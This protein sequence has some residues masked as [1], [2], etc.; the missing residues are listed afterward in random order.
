MAT[1]TIDSNVAESAIAA[2]IERN[3]PPGCEVRRAPLPAADIVIQSEDRIIMLERKTVNDFASSMT[4][5][6]LAE[7]VERMVNA[8]EDSDTPITP[9]ILI[10]GRPPDYDSVIDA[11]IK[12]KHFYG[13]MNRLQF[14]QNVKV[15]WCSSDSASIAA[16]VVQ[17]AKKLADTGFQPPRSVEASSMRPGKKRKR[18]EDLDDVRATVSSMLVGIPRVS[19][20][21]ASALLAKWPTLSAISNQSM[22]EIA[23]TRVG[24]KTVGPVLAKRVKSA[25]A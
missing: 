8:A 12:G 6:R 22:Q 2:D 5:G 17:I 14:S 13:M 21:V 9:A 7:Q 11:R 19:E 25:L 4:D 16:R 1:I 15:V 24:K 23:A 18:S 3:A 20:S 10:N